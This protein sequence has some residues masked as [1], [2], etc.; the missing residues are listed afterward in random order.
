MTIEEIEARLHGIPLPEPPIY[1]NKA[2]KI[3]DVKQFLERQLEI[4]RKFKDDPKN[5][6]PAHDRLV[7]FI[8]L[9]EVPEN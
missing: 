7:K 9:T 3:V 8:E 4:M 1:L 5:S 2:T 6:G